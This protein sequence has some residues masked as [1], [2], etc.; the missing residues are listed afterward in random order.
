MKTLI[1]VL[2][3]SLGSLIPLSI[4]SAVPGVGARADQGQEIKNDTQ[5]RRLCFFIGGRLRCFG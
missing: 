3:F 5:A 1:T 2:A 4:A